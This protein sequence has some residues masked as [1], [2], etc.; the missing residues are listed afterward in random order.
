[1]VKNLGNYQDDNFGLASARIPTKTGNVMTTWL[2]QSVVDSGPQ[3]MV[4]PWDLVISLH[5]FLGD[6]IERE[7]GVVA[8][9]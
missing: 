3:T 2:L 8:V 7:R 9:K 5:K 6:V 1:M 4:L